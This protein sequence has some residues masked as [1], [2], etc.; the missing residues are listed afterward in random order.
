MTKEERQRIKKSLSLRKTDF[1]TLEACRSFYEL[2][3]IFIN[4]LFFD[5][6]YAKQQIELENDASG[7]EISK[8]SFQ[9]QDPKW[10]PVA[11]Y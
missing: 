9:K 3:A 6:I 11:Y 4:L 2:V 7:Y 5:H 1:L 10:K 8:I